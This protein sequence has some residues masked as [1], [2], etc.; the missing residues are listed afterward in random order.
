MDK[1]IR[2]ISLSISRQLTIVSIE[3]FGTIGFL[4]RSFARRVCECY[5]YETDGKR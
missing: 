4:D 1:S 3:I 5:F 2:L